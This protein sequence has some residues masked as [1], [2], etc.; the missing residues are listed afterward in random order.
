MIMRT[1]F[2]I[3]SFFLLQ[4]C[5]NAQISPYAQ[6]G[7]ESGNEGE[8]SAKYGKEFVCKDE[9]GNHIH[10]Q[11]ISE[12]AVIVAGSRSARRAHR[13]IVRVK[14]PEHVSYKGEKYEVRDIGFRAFECSKMKEIVLPNT[15]DSIYGLAF[16]HC[17]S[18]KSIVIPNSVIVIG[19]GAFTGCERLESVVISNSV[20]Y[21]QPWTFSFCYNLKHVVLPSNLMAIG[22]Q[23]FWRTCLLK[24]DLPESLTIIGDCAFQETPLQSLHI[25]SSV[26]SI[27]V[28]A[29]QGTNL[30]SVTGLHNGIKVEPGAFGKYAF[31]KSTTQ[32]MPSTPSIKDEGYCKANANQNND[33]I[34][35][36][37]EEIGGNKYRL[38]CIKENGKYYLIYL[39]CG[40]NIPEWLQGDI[41]AYL[42]ESATIGVFK[43]KWVMQN[44]T[45][46]DDAY[47]T[48]DGK[49][50]KSFLPNGLPSEST[51]MKMYPTTSSSAGVGSDTVVEDSKW[52]GTGFAL[53]NG[54]IVT[55]HH[56]IENAQT[57][58][59]QGIGGNFS[60][61][62][63]AMVVA[64]DKNNDLA[65][66]KI[67]DTRFSGFGT[68]P[69][70]VNT[71]TSEVGEEIFVLGYPLI[72]TMGDEIK[73][74]TGVVSSKTGF[75]G[76]VSLYQISAPIQPGNSGGPLFDSKG[77]V[78][79]IVSA[80]HIGAENV[81]YAIKTS[82]LK[83]LMESAAS[84]NVLPQTNRVATLNLSDKV[85]AVKNYVY[86]IT[87][88]S[89]ANTSTTNNPN[90]IVTD[91]SN[92]ITVNSSSKTT[93]NSSSKTTTNSSSTTATNS[94]NTTT[95]NSSSSNGTNHSEGNVISG[96]IYRYPYINKRHDNSLILI[97]VQ[98][99]HNETILTFS[100][101]N[102]LVGGWMNIDRNSYIMANGSKYPLIEAEDI[103]YAPNYTYFSHQ[104]EIKTFKLRFKVI[105]MSTTTIDFIEN[106]SSEWN[107]YGI[108]LKNSYHDD[109]LVIISGVS[110]SLFSSI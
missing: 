70:K 72:S 33:G 49:I 19:H 88:S 1:F 87:C 75:Q 81:G 66:L 3:I 44:K 84:T 73:L 53:N 104:G 27:G 65:L 92:K 61:E 39:G 21:I 89:I 77:N 91:S 30:K 95:T 79:G 34:C 47:V 43:A 38:A 71:M 56:V 6:N 96:I 24:I 98:I 26:K 18:L 94:S 97:S 23:A 80:K 64:S 46:N 41:K 99:T 55:N 82:Y 9:N 20:T 32:N 50:M 40:R 62:Y 28:L 107:L 83:S 54:Y 7:H 86:Y 108:Q 8:S 12:S 15:L 2:I 36:I 58:K 101:K 5:A 67:T 35:G 90:K 25:P 37:Y 60:I 110:D 103:S 16:S 11:T 52:S 45:R 106:G 74:T 85:K 13:K 69:Y 22:F 109:N 17:R 10:Y 76:D 48:F 78:I 105:P 57:I 51:Y 4:F 68:I 59:V 14:I 63:S 31:N 93:T 29:F 100:H 42:E 102:E